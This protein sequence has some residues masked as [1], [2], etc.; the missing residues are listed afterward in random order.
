MFGNNQSDVN[1][2][3]QAAEDIDYDRL[4]L[5]YRYFNAVPAQ[6]QLRKDISHTT[7]LL[8]VWQFH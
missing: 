8:V 6:F 2:A 5:I 7:E 3:A 4:G 1:L